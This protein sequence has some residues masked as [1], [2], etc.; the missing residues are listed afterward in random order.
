MVRKSDDRYYGVLNDYDMAIW[1]NRDV[2]PSS[3]Q[4]MGTL[5]YVAMELLKEVPRP[6]RYRHDLESIFYCMLDMILE[7]VKVMRGIN[8]WR[9]ELYMSGMS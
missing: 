3:K 1:L 8:C 9:S 7:N 2:K 4:R 5:P 6:H